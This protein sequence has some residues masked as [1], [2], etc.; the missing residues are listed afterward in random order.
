MYIT[1]H[2]RRLLYRKKRVFNSRGRDCSIPHNHAPHPRTRNHLVK[3]RLWNWQNKNHLVL[4]HIIMLF[5]N[6]DSLTK[7]IKQP[8]YWATITGSDYFC[9]VLRG[10]I[11]RSSDSSYFVRLQFIPVVVSSCQ[12]LLTEGDNIRRVVQAPMLM[13]PVLACCSSTCL[14]LIHV[15]ST[16][17]LKEPDTDKHLSAHSLSK[18]ILSACIKLHSTPARHGRCTLLRSIWSKH[19]PKFSGR[20]WTSSQLFKEP[21]FSE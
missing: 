5:I 11:C 2:H 9:Q 6:D 19:F 18:S 10:N 8:V 17:M 20:A 16:A 7:R 13:S 4:K 14:H 15:E 1:L 21:L 3:Q 12:Q